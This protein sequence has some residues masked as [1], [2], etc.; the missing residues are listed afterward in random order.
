M[1]Y[2]AITPI[3][4]TLYF[5][6]TRARK[7]QKI[8]LHSVFVYSVT[9]R[10]DKKGCPRVTGGLIGQQAGEIPAQSRLLS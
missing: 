10:I 9:N 1:I 5:D 6:A 4:A 2:D 3:S 7:L 8:D